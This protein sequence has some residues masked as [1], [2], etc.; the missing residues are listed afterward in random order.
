MPAATTIYATAWSRVNNVWYGRQITFSTSPATQWLSPST[1][2]VA[3][4]SG[5]ALQWAP[6]AGAQ[7]YYLWVG[8]SLDAQ[9]VVAGTEDDVKD[10]DEEAE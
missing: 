3:L 8:T 2:G 4:L 5:A 10:E 6:V 9:N 1:P 7:A